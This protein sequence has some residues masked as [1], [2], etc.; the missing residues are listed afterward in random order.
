MAAVNDWGA[1]AKAL[2]TIPAEFVQ[3]H[4]RLFRMQASIHTGR[5]SEAVVAARTLELEI[6]SGEDA[7]IAAGLKIEAACKANCIDIVLPDIL[8]RW[9]QSIILRSL[10][11]NSLP[12][13]DPR[14][15]ALRVLWPVGND[16]AAL[17]GPSPFRP[18]APSDRRAVRRG[19]TCAR[20]C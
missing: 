1:G 8:A 14:R 3:L 15:P 12:E 11:H 19:V 7:E 2:D 6:G 16:G 4:D 20:S 9:P 10:A 13:A 17:G 18:G 5:A